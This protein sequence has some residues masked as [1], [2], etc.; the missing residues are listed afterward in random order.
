MPSNRTLI[1]VGCCL[2]ALAVSASAQTN[3]KPGLWETTT[4]MTW[5]QSPLPPGMQAPPGSPFGGAPH[6]TQVCVT[7]AMID[8]YGAPVPGSSRGNCQI[9]NVSLKLTGM[10]ATM[11]C[12]GQFSGSGT[13]ESNWTMPDHAKGKVH[14]TGTMTMGP[15]T[16]PIEWT[17]ESES[18]YKGPDCGSVQP[19]PMPAGK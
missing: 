15:N 11:V 16:R 14:F 19:L 7:Q 5:Q 1:T 2:L 8:K 4:T 6:T 13:V 10:T 9:T 17:S 12:S 3:R 18:V